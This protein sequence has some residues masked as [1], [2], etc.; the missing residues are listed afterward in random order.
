MSAWQNAPIKAQFEAASVINSDPAGI[1]M[2][3]KG[4][5]GVVAFSFYYGDSIAGTPNSSLILSVHDPLSQTM[6]FQKRVEAESFDGELMGEF[7]EAWSDAFTASGI[8]PLE[9][10]VRGCSVGQALYAWLDSTKAELMM[11]PGG[12][13]LMI[14]HERSEPYNRKV[15]AALRTA[16]AIRE[17]ELR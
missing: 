13:E 5:L 17:M 3:L 9:A 8:D 4:S 1:W 11:C 7:S 15:E 12:G 14:F 16:V 2:S 6:L 10:V